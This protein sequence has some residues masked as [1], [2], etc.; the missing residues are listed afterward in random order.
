[1]VFVSS[2][3][4]GDAL[5]SL[6]DKIR[7]FTYITYPYGLPEERELVRAGVDQFW[8]SRGVNSINKT[9]SAK[10]YSGISMFSQ[11]FGGMKNN[12]YRDYFLDLFDMMEDQI[13]Y[14]VLYPRF[15]FGPG[16]R[17]A[18]KGCYI[19][20]LTEGLQPKLIKKSEW[21]IY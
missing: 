20:T 7:N 4:L 19:V 21:V 10:V 18:S 3:M 14:S 1:M 13:G 12:R 8:Q 6:P 2:T 16:Q 11:A 17:Y 5:S 15:S 9:V